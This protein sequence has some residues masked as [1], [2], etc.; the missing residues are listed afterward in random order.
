M[1]EMFHRS[2]FCLVCSSRVNIS[3]AVF[4]LIIMSHFT[5]CQLELRNVHIPT[6]MSDFQ[7]LNT[8]W[9]VVMISSKNECVFIHDFSDLGLQIVFDTWWPFM[10]VGR[11]RP[12]S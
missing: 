8:L 5:A 2:Y 1:H 9:L 10:H 12:I 3:E 6:A 7:S 11:K 4:Y